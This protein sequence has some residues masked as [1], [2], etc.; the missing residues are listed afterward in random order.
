MLHEQDIRAFVYGTTRYFEIAVQQAASVG[1]PYLVTRG[2][3]E[4][5]D[6]NGVISV[7]GRRNGIVYFSAPRGMLTVLLMKMNE[8][9]VSNEYL[10]DLVGEV[11]NTIAGNVRR[12]LGKDFAISVPTVVS[13][14]GSVVELPAGTRPVV[15]P[16][17]WRS[18]VARLVVCLR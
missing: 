7:S 9:N 1:S 17:N 2:T 18:H 11:A 13:G 8:S 5:H 16:I 4:G 14:A 3:P 12:E 15:I 10:C 6:Y